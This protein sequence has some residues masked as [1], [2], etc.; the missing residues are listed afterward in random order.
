M[1]SSKY[2]NI[3]FCFLCNFVVFVVLFTVALHNAIPFIGFGFLDNAIMII[4]V[5]IEKLHV[6]CS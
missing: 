2:T 5:S 3:F 4:A 6:H 1:V